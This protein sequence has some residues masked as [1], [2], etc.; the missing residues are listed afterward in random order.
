MKKLLILIVAIAL[1]LH[2]YPQPEVDEKFTEIKTIALDKF[3]SATDTKVRLKSDKIYTD[4][5]HKFDSFSEEEQKYLKEITATRKQVKDF[6]LDYCK[7][8]KQTI[9]FHTVN[10]TS[11]CRTIDKYQTL[12]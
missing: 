5:E 7:G 8:D 11:V 2:F 6:Y 12:L 10:L 9:R 3:S 4:L 1:F